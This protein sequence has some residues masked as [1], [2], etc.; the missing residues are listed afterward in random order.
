[1]AYTP[2]TWQTGD[3]ITAA[4]LNKMEQGI[5]NAGGAFFVDT[6]F[7]LDTSTTTCNKTAQEIAEAFAS[8]LPVIVG[9][10]DSEHDSYSIRPIV[11]F[12]YSNYVP[13]DFYFNMVTFNSSGGT[14]SWT[15]DSASSYPLTHSA[16]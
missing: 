1:M 14:I 5:A 3:T 7:D 2:T 4:G 15:A 13:E 9:F 16:V 11:S 12:D 6:S 10:M 8:G